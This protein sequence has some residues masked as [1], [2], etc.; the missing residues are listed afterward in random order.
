MGRPRRINSL[1]IGGRLRVF[2]RLLKDPRTPLIGKLMVIGAA[3]GYGLL[4]IDFVPELFL[5]GLGFVD[6]IIIIPLIL[7]LLTWFAPTHVRKETVEEVLRER[8]DE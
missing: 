2:W 7:T 8:S 4:P 1:G 6:D 5:P 3:V